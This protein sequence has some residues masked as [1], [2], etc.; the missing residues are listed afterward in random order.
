VSLANDFSW[1]YT[2]R[3]PQAED[4]SEYTKAPPPCQ[5]VKV[6]LRGMEPL[7]D[8]LEA[9]SRQT[10]EITVTDDGVEIAVPDFEYMAVVAT[11]VRG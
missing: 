9:V 10:L 8:V 4:L 11:N 3:R 2:G 7:G 5:G 6:L 1:V